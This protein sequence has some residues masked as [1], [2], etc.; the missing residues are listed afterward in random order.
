[1]V[2]AM[3]PFQPLC[4]S[5]ESPQRQLARMSLFLFCVTENKLQSCTSI[6][7]LTYIVLPAYL[8]S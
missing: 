2:V 1:M 6:A 3:P 7:V 8:T 5:V 4:S